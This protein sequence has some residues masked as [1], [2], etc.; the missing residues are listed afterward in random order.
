MGCT[1]KFT[2]RVVLY[3]YALSN[4]LA[5]KS[6]IQK[7]LHFYSEIYS[8]SSFVFIFTLKFTR[9][10]FIK[11]CIYSVKLYH[12]VLFLANIQYFPTLKTPL[13]LR[14]PVLLYYIK[15]IKNNKT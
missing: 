4:L 3:S 9:W 2:R 6:C 14:S 13:F 11:C 5:E 12:R 1:L 8:L 15:I 7:N 10:V